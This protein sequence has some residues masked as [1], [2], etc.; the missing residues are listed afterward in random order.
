MTI[1]LK[2]IQEETS[3][4]VCWVRNDPFP[5][6]DTPTY[7]GEGANLDGRGSVDTVIQGY[8]KKNGLTP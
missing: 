6:K 3:L 2:Y 8:N 4:L 1:R 7:L 5:R